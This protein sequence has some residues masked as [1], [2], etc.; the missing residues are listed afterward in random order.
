LIFK[1]EVRTRYWCISWLT[2][3]ILSLICYI[4]G[5]INSDSNDITLYVFGFFLGIATV[6]NSY[7]LKNLIAKNGKF[8]YIEKWKMWKIV[9]SSDNASNYYNNNYATAI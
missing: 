8:S 5:W 4:Y 7:I 2:F 3:I 6:H 9:L 1:F